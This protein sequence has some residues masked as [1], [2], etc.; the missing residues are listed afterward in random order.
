[1]LARSLARSADKDK[2][3]KKKNKKSKKG[4]VSTPI[5]SDPESAPTSS[6]SLSDEDDE[7]KAALDQLL[8]E[9]RKPK[10]DA[11]FS[12]VKEIGELPVL[13][14]SS[15][16]LKSFE[17]D[18]RKERAGQ[19]HVRRVGRR[20]YKIDGE[21]KSVRKLWQN[22][23]MNKLCNNLFAGNDLLGKEKATNPKVIRG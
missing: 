2:E 4:A 14:L 11:P 1:M 21:P 22:L 17:G 15:H 18:A 20:L 6:T 8:A 5:S 16:H 12:T 10:A 23:P 7:G 13:R 19:D 9:P 3:E